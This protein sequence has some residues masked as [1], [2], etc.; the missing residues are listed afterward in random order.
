LQDDGAGFKKDTNKI[1][2][3]TKEETLDFPLKSKKAVAKDI[4]DFV[5]K[6]IL[7]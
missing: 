2:I 6:Q 5:E 1:K 7:K 3:I 4:L